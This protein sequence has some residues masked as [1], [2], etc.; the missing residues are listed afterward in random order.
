[1]IREAPDDPGGVMTYVNL[2]L[3]PGSESFLVDAARA[4]VAATIVPDLPVDEAENG[5]SSVPRTGSPPSSSRSGHVAPAA[6]G[7]AEGRPRFV[8]AWPTYGVTGARERLEEPPSTWWRRSPLTTS[9]CSSASASGR[10]AQAPRP[11]PS[12]TA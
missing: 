5:R 10:P 6:R 1:M 12:P 2:V 8:T 11:A 4:G 3:P 9:R 7:I